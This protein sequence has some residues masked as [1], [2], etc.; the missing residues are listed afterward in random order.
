MVVLKYWGGGGGGSRAKDNGTQILKLAHIIGIVGSMAC[1][2]L[3]C[4]PVLICR[5]PPPP[6]SLQEATSAVSDAEVG[7][8]GRKTDQEGEDWVNSV[9]GL[10]YFVMEQQCIV[11]ITN[12][13][14]STHPLHSDS[15]YQRHP[16]PLY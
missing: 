12:G 10:L 16:L 5:P 11:R 13:C 6:P 7:D 8:G 3:H 1:L 15:L 9:V 14:T 2:Q 4:L